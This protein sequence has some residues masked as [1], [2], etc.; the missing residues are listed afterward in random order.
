MVSNYSGLKQQVHRRVKEKTVDDMLK[1]LK[2]SNPNLWAKKTARCFL[3][4]PLYVVL[5][6]DT[7]ATIMV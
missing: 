4:K 7:S 2:K 6:K 3:A 5:F 1:F